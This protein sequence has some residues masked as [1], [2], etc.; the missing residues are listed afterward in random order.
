[1]SAKHQLLTDVIDCQC[2][3]EI[4]AEEYE[5]YYQAENDECVKRLVNRIE[6]AKQLKQKYLTLLN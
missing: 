5:N 2:L 6:E 1:M 4:I 3:F